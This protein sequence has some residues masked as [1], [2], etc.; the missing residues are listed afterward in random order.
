MSNT[1]EQRYIGSVLLEPRSLNIVTDEL[2]TYYMHGIAEARSDKICSEKDCG[3]TPLSSECHAARIV[4]W[5]SDRVVKC[6]SRTRG[7]RIS[8]TIRHVPVVSKLDVQKL[9]KKSY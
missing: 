2:Y 5:P 1:L 8:V 4:N 3:D 7:T 6:S 9:L